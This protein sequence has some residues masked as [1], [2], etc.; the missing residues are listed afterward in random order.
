M[1][2]QLVALEHWSDPREV[3]SSLLHIWVLVLLWLLSPSR[4]ESSLRAVL[5]ATC[6]S[7]C[8]PE[9]AYSGPQAWDLFTKSDLTSHPVG[10][11]IEQT[12][13]GSAQ[14]AGVALGAQ[15][16]GQNCL[17]AIPQMHVALP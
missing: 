7:Q 13:G 3:L 4:A 11:S 6:F 17:L 14:A 1:V 15:A 16:T 2:A 5:F 9:E 10:T 8:G 12:P